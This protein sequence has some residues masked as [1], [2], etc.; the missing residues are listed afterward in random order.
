[1]SAVI[2]RPAT[3]ADA[4]PMLAIYAP[5]ARDTTVSFELEPPSLE[6]FSQ[7]I[8]HCAAGWA[9][10]VAEQGDAVLGYAYGTSHRERLA[11]RFST[12]TSVYLAETARGRGLGKRLYLALFEALADKGYCHAYAVVTLPN[13]ASVGLHTA[14]GFNQVGCFPRVGRKFGQWHD[15]AW[16]HRTLREH[17]AEPA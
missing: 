3:L 6:T 10:L 1:V 5:F 16:F 12:E 15:V 13:A 4:L 7:R 17:P 2:I 9:W 8:E 11:Y 14:V